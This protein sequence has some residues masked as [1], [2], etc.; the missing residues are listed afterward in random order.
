MT[1]LSIECLDYGLP[2]M[3]TL[4]TLRRK[5][6]VLST[7]VEVLTNPSSEIVFW[8]DVEGNHKG[9]ATYSLSGHVS[10]Q[11]RQREELSQ[12]IADDIYKEFITIQKQ[13]AYSPC[14]AITKSILSLN[15]PS[16]EL[17]A[18][19]SNSAPSIN[20]FHKELV[21]N[22]FKG[23]MVLLTIHGFMQEGRGVAS[24]ND[25]THSLIETLGSAIVR[26]CDILIAAD[27]NEA[28]KIKGVVKETI[29]NTT[30]SA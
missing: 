23:A 18:V 5:G 15:D 24:T 14:S 21:G 1:T 16:P 11:G 13:A 7:R 25:A 20:A 26:S 8:L 19:I 27:Y 10:P 2:A 4:D 3:V 9:T 30:L 28:G 6:V 22:C 17:M 29:G 12:R